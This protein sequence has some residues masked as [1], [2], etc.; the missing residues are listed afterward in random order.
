MT[1]DQRRDAIEAAAATGATGACVSAGLGPIAAACGAAGAY[2]ARRA[3]RALERAWQDWWTDDGEHVT[4]PSLE[5][6]ELAHALAQ[7]R[8][9]LGVTALVLALVDEARARGYRVDAAQIWTSARVRAPLAQ[10]VAPGDAIAINV[11]RRMFAPNGLA[12]IHAHYAEEF[13]QIMRDAAVV[14][15]ELAVMPWQWGHAFPRPEPPDA[16]EQAAAMAAPTITETTVDPGWSA[17]GIHP[18]VPSTEAL[19]PDDRAPSS[20]SPAPAWYRGLGVMAAIGA[21]VL[22]LGATRRR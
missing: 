6:L 22:A 7:A 4:T 19:L 18:T 10:W 12:P 15:G 3:T 20:S 8:A 16:A 9:T 2:V 17:I 21:V 14:L 13:D 5:E 1:P 11:E